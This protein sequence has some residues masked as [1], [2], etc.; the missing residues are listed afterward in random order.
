MAAAAS[1]SKRW[2][3]RGGTLMDS[4]VVRVA[5]AQLES[6]VDDVDYN[7]QRARSTI[8][9]AAHK[10]ARVVVF[11]ELY[12]HGYFV[13]ELAAT[14]AITVPDRLSESLLVLTQEL[15]VYV[16]IGLAR[17]DA[18]FPHLVYNSCL[19]SGPQG[20]IGWYDKT[21][22]GTYLNYREGCYFAPGRRIKVFPTDF[23]P[24][25]IE[26]CYD[27][28]YPEVARVLALKGAILHLVLS[29]G[30]KE[31][32]ET[33]PALLKVRSMENAFLLCTSTP[34]GSR[35]RSGSSVVAE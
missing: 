2:T 28:S 27:V 32:Q 4:A 7:W 19:F 31:F 29:A 18:G 16:A 21:H 9:N 13:D 25:G 20:L 33:W 3:A 30:P 8:A 6:R 23:G 24:V 35:N 17:T 15:G 34:W 14:R 22:L 12:L 26:I 11:P 5:L 1:A 10:G